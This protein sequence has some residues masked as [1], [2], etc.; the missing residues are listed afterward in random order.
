M[1][2]ATLERSAESEDALTMTA[3]GTTSDKRM[4]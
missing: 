2:L 3:L 4:A 1:G